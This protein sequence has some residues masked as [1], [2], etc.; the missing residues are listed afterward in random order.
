M[1]VKE[2]YLSTNVLERKKRRAIEEMSFNAEN[3]KNTAQAKIK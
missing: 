1:Q 3:V 2:S